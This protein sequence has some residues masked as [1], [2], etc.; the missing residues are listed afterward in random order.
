MDNTIRR[1]LYCAMYV[2]TFSTAPEFPRCV[3]PLFLSNSHVNEQKSSV[4]IS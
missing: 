4:Q 2:V 1:F 3:T